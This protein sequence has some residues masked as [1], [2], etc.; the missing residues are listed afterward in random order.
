MAGAAHKSA[1]PARATRRGKQLPPADPTAAL[2]RDAAPARRRKAARK[3]R[4]TLDSQVLDWWRELSPRARAGYRGLLYATIGGLVFA[5][6]LGRTT[7]SAFNVLGVVA[8]ALFGWS[9]Y[10][11]AVLVFALGAIRMLESSLDVSYVRRA[12]VVESF[13]LWA[14]VLAAS[15]L[16]ARHDVGG[17]GGAVLAGPLEAL[18]ASAGVALVFGAALVL[19]LMLASV[20]P[21]DVAMGVHFAARQAGEGVRAGQ[22]LMTRTGSTRTRTTDHA[23]DGDEDDA[24]GIV[25]LERTPA[26]RVKLA[27]ARREIGL[28][29]E[30]DDDDLPDAGFSSR[31]LDD[32]NEDDDEDDDED[33][34]EA[35][36]FPD[37]GGGNVPWQLPSLDLLDPPA[38]PQ[39]AGTERV[40]ELAQRLEQALRAFRVDAE[41]RREDISVGPTIIRF[42]VRPIERP[43]RDDRGRMLLGEDGQP[44]M[45]RTR[46]SRILNLRNDLALALEAHSLRMEAPVPGQPY[47]GIEIPRPN[48][49]SV[50]LR[51]ILL[52]DSFTRIS[53]KSRVAVA[54]GRDVSGK[55][56]AADIAKFPHVLVA[57][58]TGAGKS[59]CLN[60]FLVSILT[61][62]TPDEVRLV[63]VDPKKVELTVYNGVPHLLTPVITDTKE[64]AGVLKQALDE[65]ERRYQLF[66]QLGVRNLEGYRHLA[67]QEPELETLPNIVIVIDE[68]ADLMMAAPDEVEYM[69]CRLAQLARA[70]GLHLVVATQRPSVDVI[71]G[72][73]KANIPTRIAFMVSSSVDSRT[74][75]DMGGAEHLLGRGDMLFMAADASKPERIQGSFVSDDEVSRLVRFWRQQARRAG[76]RVVERKPTAVTPAGTGRSKKAIVRHAAKLQSALAGV[77]DTFDELEPVAVDPAR[78]P[79]PPLPLRGELPPDLG[80]TTP[81]APTLADPTLDAEMQPADLSTLGWPG[82]GVD[83]P[84]GVRVPF[85]YVRPSE[86]G[87]SVPPDLWLEH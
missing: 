26:P 35:L 4:S 72:L 66:A 51:E 70:T 53:E 21:R 33:E 42:G 57:G 84:R 7:S 76:L 1:S 81:D 20:A 55:P 80:P 59:V 69:I 45:V 75:L 41:V 67:K 56:R 30:E 19:V 12:M 71:T 25:P 62:A 58:A 50:L 17:I 85:E 63:L 5:G 2:A 54:L 24:D 82:V 32:D 68:L 13:S 27:D 34:D 77:V 52:S 46:V 15:H 9:A 36:G 14:V 74:I 38:P 6:L 64:V 29:D 39:P 83:G 3:R 86:T 18:P 22:S 16:L 40:E 11:L 61:T 28:D 49:N 87:P 60:A 73:I 65:M 47:V 43:R 10:P 78:L 48:S 37:A 79:L 23:L 31:A 8:Y 44:I